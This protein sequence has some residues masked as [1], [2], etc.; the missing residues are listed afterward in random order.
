[1]DFISASQCLPILRL[2]ISFSFIILGLYG[3][4]T[5]IIV[6][7]LKMRSYQ[8][9]GVLCSFTPLLGVLSRIIVGETQHNDAYWY[10]KTLSKK[11]VDLNIELT[12][13]GSHLT[14]IL[15]SPKIIKEF[16]SKQAYYRKVEAPKSIA[17][18][19]GTGLISA[20]GNLWKNHRRIISTLFHFNFLKQQV[21]VIVET[22]R[23]F[24]NKLAPNR[25]KQ[26]VVVDE[27]QKITGEIVGRIFFSENLNQYLIKG[28]PMT[29]FLAEL[30]NKSSLSFRHLGVILAFGTGVDPE[31]V[32]SYND[33]MNDVRHFRESCLQI[34]QDRKNSKNKG[35]DLLGLMLATQ[36]SPKPEDRF[37]D[38]DI[39][40]EFI[41]LFLA[42]MDTTG[43]LITMALYELAKHP[44]CLL[45]AEDEVNTIYKN[46]TNSVVTIEVLNQMD[47]L[48]AIFKE[49]LRFYIPVPGV[50]PR[51]AE[52]DHELD[53]IKIKKG[54]SVTINPLYN[55]FNE[56][57]FQEPESFKPERWL[58]KQI[59]DIDPYVYT[60]FSAG[61]RNC[62]GQHFA[63]I[64]AK[65]V[66]SEFLDLFKYKITP[67]NYKLVL[68]QAFL[69][70][71]KEKFLLNLQPKK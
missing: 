23:E 66:V 44:I 58:N 50:F 27:I 67:E 39:I 17:V 71:P 41:T 3:L 4:I 19:M 54:M 64:Q 29:L 6:P 1:M 7:L 36:E 25:E 43:H 61:A 26:V 5:L 28:L 52:T 13:L 49:V 14:W 57:Y 40:N 10:Y 9:K 59:N 12:N 60:P 15:Y 69:Y 8:K 38:E 55:Y 63:I 45:K 30:T 16:Y 11:T 47:Y 68:T 46:K 56:Q 65:I 20:E 24:L 32:P 21:P 48:H 53:G 18:L 35:K 42:G 2:V 31:W 22:A 62:I 34:V 70:A 33:L 37:A 51:I